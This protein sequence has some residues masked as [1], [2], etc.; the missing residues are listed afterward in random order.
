MSFDM[1]SLPKVTTYPWPHV[2]SRLTPALISTTVI[3]KDEAEA[4]FSQLIKELKDIGLATQVRPGDSSSLLVF[5][6]AV[7]E[8][9]FRSDIYR[10]RLQDWLYGV[11]PAAPDEDLSK[12][13]EEEPVTEAERL[14][15]LYRLITK[16]KDEGG[17]GIIPKSS[18]WKH[19][20]SIFPLHNHAFNQAWLKEWSKKYLLDDNDISQIRNKFGEKVAL[21]FAFLQA[22]FKFLSFPAIFGFATWI[23]IGE[24]SWLYAII[25]SVWTVVFFEYWKQKEGDLAGQWGVRGVSK[26]QLPRPEFQF[27]YEAEDPVTREIVKV[28]PAVKRFKTQLLQ[29]PFAIAC[30]LVLGSLIAT[31]YSIEIFIS[32]VYNGPG[33]TYM[34]SRLLLRTKIQLN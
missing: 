16:P 25:N 8:K 15:L 23:L 14:R 32:E 29:I 2:Y 13:F 9:C 31:A 20:Q 17:A 6:K 11:R 22:Y 33:K 10:A 26:I 21:Y 24:F 4:A 28:Y 5:I 3:D 1:S 34:V 19:V 30:G 12:H 7:S 18:T 27:E